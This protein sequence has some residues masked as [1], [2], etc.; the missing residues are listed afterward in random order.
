M[1]KLAFALGRPRRRSA[2]C[3][4]G[5]A[6]GPDLR[7]APALAQRLGEPRFAGLTVGSLEIDLA[8]AISWQGPTSSAGRLG[9]PLDWGM[10][11]SFAFEVD[12]PPSA[13][14]GITARLSTARAPSYWIKAPILGPALP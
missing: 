8:A 4:G 7:L 3:A 6:L 12:A 11:D 5:P 1:R 10:A 14:Q 2:G 9:A 13:V